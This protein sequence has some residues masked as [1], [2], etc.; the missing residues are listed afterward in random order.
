VAWACLDHTKFNLN[1]SNR[2]ATLHQR[3]S[4]TERQDRQRSDSVGRTVLQ[5]VAQKS[6]GALYF[7]RFESIVAYTLSLAHRKNVACLG[8]PRFSFAI[9]RSRFRFG[10]YK[11]AR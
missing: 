2:L 8:L 10:V 1:P 4:Q 7:A 9:A 6:R 3:Y 5:T 11:V